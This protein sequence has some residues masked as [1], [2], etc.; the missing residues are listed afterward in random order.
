MP[1]HSQ[2]NGFKF[3]NGEQE[4]ITSVQS[5]FIT[6]LSSSPLLHSSLS[7][8]FFLV[9]FVIEF[10]RRKTQPYTKKSQPYRLKKKKIKSHQILADQDTWADLTKAIKAHQW[11]DWCIDRTNLC[12]SL[13][14]GWVSLYPLCS[15]FCHGPC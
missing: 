10:M 11:S 1:Q 8:S 4:P 6:Q 7:N 12:S 5:L 15:T 3:F 14:K 13:Q 2:C 9:K